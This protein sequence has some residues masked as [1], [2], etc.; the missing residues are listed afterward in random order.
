MWY[1]PES[2]GLICAVS[3]VN[4]PPQS[5]IPYEDWTEHYQDQFPDWDL[6]D[7]VISNPNHWD[8]SMRWDD[9]EKKIRFKGK[10]V[11]PTG[12]FEEVVVAMHSYGHPRVEKTVELFDRKFRCLACD[13]PRG[14]GNLS[15]DIPKILGRCHECPTTKAR[16][17]KQCEFAPVPQYQ[18]TSLAIDVCK[19]PECLQK[20]TGK[21]VDY[22]MVIVCR[23]TGY[24]LAIPC[25][26][27]RWDTKSA[28]FLFL[29]TFVR[30]FGLPKEFIC[31]NA[32]VIDSESLKEL[33]AMSE[34]EQHSFVAYP[35][36]SNGR[37]ERAVQSIVNSVRQYLEQHGSSSKHSWVESLPLAHWALNDLPRAVSGYSPHPLLFRRDPVGWGDCLPVSLQHGAENAGQC[38][39]RMLDE[40]AEV[41][42]HLEDLH[43][44]EFAKFL[45]KHPEQSFKPGDRVW[46]R[47]CIVE[48]PVHGKLKIAWQGPCEVLRRISPGT[49]R[50]NIRGREEI[51]TSR[52]RKP[53][54]PYKDDK[55]VP[56]HYYTDREGL[57]ENDD[58][59]VELV[60]EDRVVRGNRQWR[61]KFRGLLEPEWHYAGSFLQN[62]NDTWARYNCRKGMD[63]SLS[64]LR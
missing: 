10:I 22:L 24:V 3:K 5:K 44:K 45:A 17:G 32:S 7:P 43:A 39:C 64:D 37:A 20:S 26:E 1:W 31:D 40:R 23:R 4:L 49:Y 27:K 55:K 30:M 8:Y 12:L 11:C 38:F 41:R 36:Q 53:Y 60:L 34:V 35:P 6:S 2:E 47:N 25:Q 14:S 46:V 62:I 28:A 57:I 48:P 52:R 13:L 33:F 51:F 59:V 15:P 16:R 56:L 58:Y 63:V 54:V 61:V 50:V 19:L 18:F 9:D 42:K 29:D 21:K